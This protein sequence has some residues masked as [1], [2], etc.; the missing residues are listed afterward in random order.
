VISKFGRMESQEISRLHH[1]LEPSVPRDRKPG[2]I[3]GFPP[4]RRFVCTSTGHSWLA[5]RLAAEGIGFIAADNAFVRIDDWQGALELADG[6]SAR[7]AAPFA[8]PL[9]RLRPRRP[10]ATPGH[11]ACYAALHNSL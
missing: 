3:C 1:I 6:F 9:C 11:Q 10:R 4:G 7:P 2:S 8:R 5:R